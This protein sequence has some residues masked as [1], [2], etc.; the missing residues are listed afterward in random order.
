[1]AIFASNL[2]PASTDRTLGSAVIGRSLRFNRSDDP[3]L[4]RTATTTS[5][6]FTYSTWVKRSNL[7]T[8]QYLFSIGGQGLLFNT[9]DT[10]RVYTDGG[11]NAS[12][13]KFRDTTSWY[14]VVLSMNSGSATVYVNNVTHLS[15]V[16]GFS[17][18]TST[19]YLKVGWLLGDPGQFNLDGYLAET[20]LIDGSALTPS[21]F[22]FTDSQTGMWMPKRYEGSY[23][24]SGF[25]LDYSDNSSTSALGIDKSPNGNDFTVNNFSVSAGE[26]DDSVIDTPTKKFPT[27]NSLDKAST[28]TLKSGNLQINTVSNQNYDGVRA[29]FGTKTGK[30]YWEIKF[31]TTGYLS[32]I[33]I[34]R[35]DGR[36]KTGTEPDYRIVLGLGSWYNTYNSGGVATYV[37]TTP[38]SDYPSVATWSGASNYSNN[39][40]Y[41]IAVDFDNGKMWW[42]KN[43]SWFNN[44]GTANPATGTDPRIT[45]TTGNEWF[46]Y[47]QE[48]DSSTVPQA[49]N[50]GQQGFAYT[51]PSG[52]LAL[53]SENL[54]SNVPSIIRPQRHFDTLLYTATGNAMTVTGLEF[55]PDFIWQKRR[56]ATSGSHFH[57]LFNS[58]VGGRYGLQSNTNGA[59]F[60]TSDAS[61]IVFKDGGFDMAASSGGQGNAASGT[62]VAWCWKAGGAAVANSDG[63][64][65]SQV[66]VNTEAGFSIVTYTGTGSST[67]IG[68]GLGKKPEMIFMKS[69]SATGDWAVLDKSNSTAEYTFYLNDNNAY[70]SS[71]GYTFYADTPPTSS[72]W[73]V[74]SASATNASG[75]TYVAYCWTSIPGYSKIGKYSGNSLSDGAYVHLG[76]RP[77]WVLFKRNDYGGNWFIV[78]NKRDVDNECT[79]DLYPNNG[80]AETNNTNFVDFLSD[81]FKLRTT[82]TAV[83]AGTIVYMAFAEQPGEIPFETLANAR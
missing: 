23:G 34:A 25:R 37:N 29:T 47:S 40:V 17:L 1:M 33:G 62:Y 76:F 26:G 43:N 35:A 75:V 56:D 4:Q 41:M 66:S 48:G 32:A 45:F 21:S 13:G 2:A 44:S 52:F 42:G 58:V 70:G 15:S 27:L 16:S 49:Y 83:N 60:D 28:I 36:I 82:G 79:R 38:S 81:G 73:T 64:T 71:S 50:F 77:A 22:G 39:D 51:P 19:N 80:N 5:N 63:A 57:Y 72:V 11:A 9:D 12:T 46:P 61:N 20:Q 24:T 74:N 67:T 68:H 69:R 18:S 14:H 6:T 8:F 65:A 59:E 53:S 78:D 55:K 3:Q 7:S 10:I 54:P 31:P 30:Y